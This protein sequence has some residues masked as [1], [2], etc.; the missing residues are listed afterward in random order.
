[1]RVMFYC[2]YVLGIG[3]WVRSSQIVRALAR[4]S[5]VLFVNGGVPLPG[6]EIP[7]GVEVVQLPA[8]ETSS[9]FHRLNAPGQTGS[10]E[11]V[12]QQRKQSLE[13]MLHRFRP[14]V[15]VI[16]M[17]PFG[18]KRFAGELLPLLERARTVSKPPRIACSVRDILVAKKNQAAFEEK[19]CQILSRYFD[20]VLVHGD[21]RFQKLDETFSRVNDIRCPVCYSGYVTQPAPVEQEPF[22]CADR[23]DLCASEPCIITSI[24]SGRYATGHLLLENVIEAAGLL[25]ETIPHRFMIFAGPFV[26][27]AV[28]DRLQ[29]MALNKP[30]VELNKYTP[31]FQAMMRRAQLSISMGGY[32]TTMNVLS[33]G[34]RAL[35]FPHT[36]ND[37][38]EQIIRA[39]K[40]QEMGALSVLDLEDLFPW[41][42]AQKITAA[43]A[44]QPCPI[45][46]NLNGAEVSA[47]IL[48]R[49][50]Q[51]EDP[52]ASLC[53]EAQLQ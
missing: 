17:F 32:N 41:A 6:Y 5:E 48:S 30:N 28:Y 11:E 1:M 18:R 26:P 4:Q 29:K 33:T 2:Q 15:L 49:L 22:A 50:G 16:E 23:S 10:V 52:N 21:S 14:D 7:R 20:L 40:L 36:A 27:D 53:A 43:L 12:Q 19:A 13:D 46:I 35:M 3:H 39:R 24:G 25:G 38:Q 9:D 45:D 8:L 51:G 31:D 42:L 37:D 34:I 47:G 44:Q